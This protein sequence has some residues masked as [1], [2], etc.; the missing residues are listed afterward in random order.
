MTAN[1]VAEYGRA[2]MVLRLKMKTSQ[3][4]RQPSVDV[5]ISLLPKE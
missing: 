3:G 1:E 5:N 2:R 4:D